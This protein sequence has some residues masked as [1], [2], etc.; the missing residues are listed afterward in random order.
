MWLPGDLLSSE[1]PVRGA[2]AGVQ[3]PEVQLP[4]EVHSDKVQGP[5]PHILG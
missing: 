1:I 5:E 2:G 3:G 4:G